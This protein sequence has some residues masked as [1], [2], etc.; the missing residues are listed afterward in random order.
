MFDMLVLNI[1]SWVRVVDVWVGMVCDISLRN[2]IVI[3]MLEFELIVW[4][5]VNVIVKIG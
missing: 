4:L 3:L 5:L 2:W 1:N